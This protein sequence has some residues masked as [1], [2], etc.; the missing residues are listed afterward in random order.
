MDH[1][2]GRAGGRKDKAV[3]PQSTYLNTD[4]LPTVLLQPPALPS[5]PPRTGRSL[6]PSIWWSTRFT[7]PVTRVSSSW[8]PAHGRARPMAAGPGRNPTAQVVL[9]AA[10][11]A[12]VGLLCAPCLPAGITCKS[13]I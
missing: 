4:L 3:L 11:A 13:G 2:P 5:K 7:S 1:G 6:A 8:G 12:A 10:T 9:W